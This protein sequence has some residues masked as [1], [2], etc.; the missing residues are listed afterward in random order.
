LIKPEVL[1]R[2]GDFVQAAVEVLASEPINFFKPMRQETYYLKYHRLINFEFTPLSRFI[3][4]HKDAK[5]SDVDLQLTV[6]E[7]KEGL[8]G[9]ALRMDMLKN[10]LEASEK[11]KKAK[12]LT[13]YSSSNRL[14]M[15]IRQGKATVIVGLKGVNSFRD[16]PEWAQVLAKQGVYFVFMDEPSFLFGEEGLSEQGKKIVKAL[17][18]S[19]LLLIVE[20][21]DALQAKALLS[22]SKK[23]LILLEKDLPDKDVLELIKKKKSALGLIL[24]Q[25]E[26]PSS[27]FEKIDEVKKTIGSDYLM[28]VNEQCLWGNEGKEQLRKVISEIIRAEYRRPDVPN[29]FTFTF[30]RVLDK[31]RGERVPQTFAYRPF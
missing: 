14:N 8:S 3:E 28:M 6:L 16:Q 4:H 25:G 2:T 11:I 15:D 17:N 5:D 10:L 21:L 27:Y 24:S 30:L 12:G 1:K 31:A 19:G 22:S 26:E 7:E 23:P 20:G 9:D 18:A 29:I 13:F